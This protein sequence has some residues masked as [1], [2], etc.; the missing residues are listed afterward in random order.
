MVYLQIIKVSTSFLIPLKLI[1]PLHSKQ[2]L[3]IREQL[4]GRLQRLQD[5]VST[6]GFAALEELV[7]PVERVEKPQGTVVDIEPKSKK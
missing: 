4:P 1:Y 5:D 6:E 7:S 2:S 3:V